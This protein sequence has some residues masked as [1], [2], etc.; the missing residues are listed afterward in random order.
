MG[1]GG[2]RGVFETKSKTI[3][4]TQGEKLRIMETTRK[5]RGGMTV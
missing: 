3:D 1:G 2:I 5:E 4:P